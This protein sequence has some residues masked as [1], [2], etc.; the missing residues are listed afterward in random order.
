MYGIGRVLFN[1]TVL[2]YIKKDSFDFGGT[3]GEISEIWAEQVQSTPVKSLPRSN[4]TI[5]PKFSLIQMNFKHMAAILGGS[6]VGP[7][8][9]PTGWGA[10][11]EVVVIEGPFVIETVS[12]HRITIA[13]GLMQGYITGPLNMTATSEIEVTLSPQLPAEPE[14]PPYTI[15]EMEDDSEG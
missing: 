1:S 9:T 5:K 2:G 11:R 8:A 14:T 3:A 6:L 12:G 7:A 15:E 4:G 10:P 13:N